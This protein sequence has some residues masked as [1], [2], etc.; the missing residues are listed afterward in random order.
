[1]TDDTPLSQAQGRLSRDMLADGTVY[2]LATQRDGENSTVLSFEQLQAS[3][4][5]FL[6]DDYHG[7]DIWI[8][9]YGSL[10]WNPLIS[11]QERCYGRLYGFHRRFCL[12]TRMRRRSP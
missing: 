12:W 5:A 1:M 7:P 9:G 4:R 6:P 10:I 8:F 3:R 11:F 2:K